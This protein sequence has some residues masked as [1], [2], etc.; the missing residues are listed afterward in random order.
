MEKHEQLSADNIKKLEDAYR[1]VRN[2]I[3]DNDI[4]YVINKGTAKAE[5]LVESVYDW[6]VKLGRQVTLLYRMVLD[7]W[8]KNYELPWATIAAIVAALLYFIN[9]FD[10]FPDF[11]PVVGYI[12]DAFVMT[13]CIRLIQKDLKSYARKNNIN[14]AE[15]G[16]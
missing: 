1:R 12:D 5:T 10:I 7:Y 9:P 3:D 2:N 4:K 8:N 14:L 11:I 6:I 13:F 16:L 15:Y